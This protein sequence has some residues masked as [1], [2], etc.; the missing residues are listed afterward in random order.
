MRTFF[1]LEMTAN[2]A[3]QVADWRDR[4]L[5]QA[6]RPVQPANFH[7]TLA[8][9]GEL[10]QGA[11]E[12]LLQ[13]VDDW[14]VPDA[15]PADQLLLDRTGYWQKQGIYWLGPTTWPQPL[16]HLA[17]KLRNLA[18]G[19]GA[20]LDRKP[21][22]PHVTLYRNYSEAPPAPTTAPAIMMAYEGF[23]LFES[24]QGRRGVS[25]HPLHYWAL[26]PAAK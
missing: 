8:F 16:T 21:F 15:V 7:I 1:G 14:L 24:R 2:A 22:Q 3:L 11:L 23:A 13:S 17:K 26:S 20:R 12:R 10:P 25:Y 4:Q 9:V 19:V 6:G 18:T 5:A